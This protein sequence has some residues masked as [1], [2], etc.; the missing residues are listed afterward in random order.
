MSTSNFAVKLDQLDAL[1]YNRPDVPK[2]FDYGEKKS[3]RMVV[4]GKTKKIP[5]CA[6]I[7][8]LKFGAGL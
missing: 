1:D 4:D 7:S 2:A 6:P 5:F 3:F 8:D